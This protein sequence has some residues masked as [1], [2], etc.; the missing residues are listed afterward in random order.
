MNQDKNFIELAMIMQQQGALN[1]PPTISIGTV[2]QDFPNVKIKINDLELDKEFFM[3]PAHMLKGYKRAIVAE[4][5]AFIKFDPE[6]A[7]TNVKEPLQ[8]GSAHDGGEGASSH[9]H[10]VP[11]HDHKVKKLNLTTEPQNF[12]LTASGDDGNGKFMTY[13][14]YEIKKGDKVAIQATGDMQLYIVLCKIIYGGDV[15]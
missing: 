13:T 7:V 4:G 14:D 5:N 15:K 2:T 12:K 9:S 11:E 8:T 1:N 6:F 10:S 3:F